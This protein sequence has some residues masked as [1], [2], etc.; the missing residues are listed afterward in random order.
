MHYIEKGVKVLST[1][2]NTNALGRIF[3]HKHNI[4]TYLL[5]NLT[6]SSYVM[7]AKIHKSFTRHIMHFTLNVRMCHP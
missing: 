1:L 2:E 4:T 3:T 7:Y 5:E 6:P